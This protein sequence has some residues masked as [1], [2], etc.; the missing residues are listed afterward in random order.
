MRIQVGGGGGEELSLPR[1]YLCKRPFE[2]VIQPKPKFERKKVEKGY[3]YVEK[4]EKKRQGRNKFVKYYLFSKIWA[5]LGENIFHLP[6]Q[7]LPNPGYPSQPHQPIILIIEHSPACMGG[8]EG[9]KHHFR[10]FL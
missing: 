5:I 1:N 3:K 2:E 4:R 8:G 10:F 9:L 6:H 7:D